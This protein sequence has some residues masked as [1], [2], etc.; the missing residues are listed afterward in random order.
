MNK[1]SNLVDN[2]D[3]MKIV[4]EESCTF[5]IA[6]YNLSAEKML[7]ESAF[8]DTGMNYLTDDEKNVLILVFKNDSLKFSDLRFKQTPDFLVI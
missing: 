8:A 6:K 1:E 3:T 2:G 4:S 7:V 5:Q